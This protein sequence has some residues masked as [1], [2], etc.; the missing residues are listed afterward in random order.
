MTTRGG[1]S[2]SGSWCSAFSRQPPKRTLGTSSHSVVLSQCRTLG[3]CRSVSSVTETTDAGQCRQLHMLPNFSE[4]QIA[5]LD[6]FVT[7]R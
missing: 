5:R 4:L 6:G 3:T 1:G 7:S 2:W